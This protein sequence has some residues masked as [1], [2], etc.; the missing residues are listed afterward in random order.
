MKEEKGVP[1]ADM[2]SVESCSV[3][4][5]TMLV[6]TAKPVNPSDKNSTLNRQNSSMHRCSQQDAVKLKNGSVPD[7]EHSQ[8]L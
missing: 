4:R 7:R 1:L 5:F 2:R 8:Y 3:W 6:S